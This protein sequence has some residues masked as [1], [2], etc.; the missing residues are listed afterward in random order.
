M[1]EHCLGIRSNC[2]K[3]GPMWGNKWTSPQTTSSQG[4]EEIPSWIKHTLSRS[5]WIHQQCAEAAGSPS[6]AR[7]W[8]CMCACGERETR[9]GGEAPLAPNSTP[10]RQAALWKPRRKPHPRYPWRDV[11]LLQ[12]ESFMMTKKL[13]SGSVSGRSLLQ[14]KLG[15]TGPWRL[16][17]QCTQSE[18][19]QVEIWSKPLTDVLAWHKKKGKIVSSQLSRFSPES[20]MYL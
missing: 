14:G 18:L 6:A 3:A 20:F 8:E 19:L 16:Q 2:S 5:T 11:K 12:S 1:G 4:S 17:V 13:R 15:K 7:E 10:G 9:G